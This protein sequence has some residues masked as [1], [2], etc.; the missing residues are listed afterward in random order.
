[1]VD[2]HESS[3]IKGFRVSDGP[4]INIA[5][6]TNRHS[7]VGNRRTGIGVYQTYIHL[8]GTVRWG[9]GGRVLVFTR[10]TST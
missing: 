1:M 5:I 9:I 10:L 4:T 6:S 7:Q 2:S 8:T 3:S